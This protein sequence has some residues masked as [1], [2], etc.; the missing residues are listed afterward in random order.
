M[1]ADRLA[2]YYRWIEYAAFGSALE[3]SRAAFVHRLAGTRRVL[4]LGEGDGR[5]LKQML[6][7]APGT[8]FDVIEASAEMIAFARDHIGV[9]DRVSFYCQDAP[10]ASFREE[11]RRRRHLLLSGL[12]HRRPVL[13]I[14]RIA[15]RLIPGTIG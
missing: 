11:L 14:Q 12:F 4:V 9:S 13:R 7:A 5:A 15:P 1:N 3:R 10:P 8:R 2:R 6:A